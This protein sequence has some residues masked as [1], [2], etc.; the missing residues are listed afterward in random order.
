MGAQRIK[1]M[2]TKLASMTKVNKKCLRIVRAPGRANLIGE[3]TDYNEGYVVPCTVNKEMI[4]AGQPY[5]DEVVLHSMSL[6]VTTKFS[7]E[8]IRFN[9]QERWANYP[10]VLARKLQKPV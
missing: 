10:K 2:L 9:P 4:I 8:N 7:L 1:A 5:K 3:H 6:T